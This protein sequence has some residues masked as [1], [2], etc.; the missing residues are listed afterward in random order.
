MS[1]RRAAWSLSTVCRVWQLACRKVL[2]FRFTDRPQFQQPA[3]TMNQCR[4]H[5]KLSTA[6]LAG[7]VTDNLDLCGHPLASQVT[8]VR[9]SGEPV[10]VSFEYAPLIRLVGLSRHLAFPLCALS[11][12]TGK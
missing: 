9:L 3:R 1:A 4:I 10:R 2:K 5:P 6:I 12:T 8:G 11:G 7:E